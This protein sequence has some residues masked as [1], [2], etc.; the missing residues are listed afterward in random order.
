VFTDRSIHAIY[1]SGNQLQPYGT[2]KTLSPTG[3]P[4]PNSIVSTP[5]GVYFFGGD[6]FYLYRNDNAIPMSEQLGD[7]IEEDFNEDMIK[8]IKG[9]YWDEKIVWA[10]SVS[11]DTYLDTMLIYD[12][13]THQ[14]DLLWDSFKCVDMD[15]AINSD[16]GR[17]Y[18][19]FNGYT[20]DDNYGLS[21]FDWDFYNDGAYNADYSGTATAGSGVTLTDSAA[22]FPIGGAGLGGVPVYINSG[23]GIGQRRFI[24]SNTA[25]QLVVPP[26]DT[27]PDTTSKYLIGQIRGRARTGKQTLGRPHDEKTF[28]SVEIGQGDD[29]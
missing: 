2:R 10:V 6:G 22:A 21:Y 24:E 16:T 26:W 7:M 27:V 3:T 19:L 28:S 11:D 4:S 13:R 9:V 8:H 23:T 20:G 25:T 14:W 29:V 15:T 17:H 12:L 1:R 18:L 5:E